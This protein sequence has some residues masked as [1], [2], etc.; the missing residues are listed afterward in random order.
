MAAGK[1]GVS[2]TQA[3]EGKITRGR[4]LAMAVPSGRVT[5]P[6]LSGREGRAGGERGP[7]CS[8]FTSAFCRGRIPC[9]PRCF[10]ATATAPTGDNR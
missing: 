10:P 1:R 2:H 4:V 8:T 9:A 6:S 5:L 3:W 7:H